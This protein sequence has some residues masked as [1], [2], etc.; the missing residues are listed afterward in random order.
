MWTI[1][2][3]AGWPIWLIIAASVASVAIILDRV[4]ALRRGV[5]MP[6][7]IMPLFEQKVVEPTYALPAEASAS[8]LGRIL[9]AAWL[10]DSDRSAIRQDNM[11]NQAS[12][13][14]VVLEKHL[15]LLGTIAAMAPL[16][17]LLGTVIGMIEIFAAQSPSGTDPQQLARG[18]SVALYNTAFGLLVA[19]PSMMFYRHFRAK[20]DVYLT[21]MEV[22]AN[23]LWHQLDQVRPECPPDKG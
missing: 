13:E 10:D 6:L 1:I 14:T 5:V 21:D 19:I 23:R 15:T 3:Q 16:L 7:G 8:S 22:V 17:G 2:Q 18:I 9:S 4:V 20:V 11:V 12:L